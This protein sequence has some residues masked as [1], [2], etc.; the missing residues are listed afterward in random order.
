MYNLL[1]TDKELSNLRLEILV[2]AFARTI[3]WR[4][5]IGANGIYRQLLTT[6]ERRQLGIR[7]GNDN[8]FDPLWAVDFYELDLKNPEDR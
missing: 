6:S 5:Y 4:G 1:N 2:T 3:D 7:L 8:M